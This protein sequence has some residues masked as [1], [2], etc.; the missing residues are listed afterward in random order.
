MFH[1]ISQDFCHLLFYLEN[2]FPHK[3]FLISASSLPSCLQLAISIWD[4]G[5]RINENLYWLTDTTHNI[6]LLVVS[7]VAASMFSSAGKHTSGRNSF[8]SVLVSICWVNE[9]DSFAD[10]NAI[11]LVPK[12]TQRMVLPNKKDDLWS[13]FK[14]YIWIKQIMCCIKV[15]FLI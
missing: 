3:L 12:R 2:K 14:Y 5:Q 13:G 8:S 9:E 4:K 10:F 6:Q 15:N 11:E 1:F 7:P